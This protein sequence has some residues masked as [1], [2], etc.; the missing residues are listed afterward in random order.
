MSIEKAKECL[1]NFG[2]ADNVLEFEVSSVAVELAVAADGCEPER[3]AKT[4]SFAAGDRGCVYCLRGRRVY[5]EPED[6]R[7]RSQ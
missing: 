2:K 1:A 7:G 3:V 6:A 5:R 4:L